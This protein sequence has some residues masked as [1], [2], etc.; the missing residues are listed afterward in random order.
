MHGA[1]S[2]RTRELVR[3]L[4]P[5]GEQRAKTER[6]ASTVLNGALAAGQREH[7]AAVQAA[8]A[9]LSEAQVKA[10]RDREAKLQQLAEVFAGEMQAAHAERDQELDL[11]RQATDRLEA[12]ANKK[13]EES[14]WLADTLA[15]SG[16]SKAASEFEQ[17]SNER[18]ARLADLDGVLSRAG[19]LL[20]V[21]NHAS[22]PAG[23]PAAVVGEAGP[24]GLA[25][26]VA[27]CRDALAGLEG[28]VR[29]AVLRLSSILI[30]GIV[31]VLAG[32]VGLGLARQ[33][34]LW[35]AIG[36]GAGAVL[37]AL[38]ALAL[39]SALRVRVPAAAQALADRVAGARSAIDQMMT[40][41]EASRAKAVTE[42][43]ARRDAEIAKGQKRYNEAMVAVKERREEDEPRV[44]ARHQAAE[45]ALHRRSER[46]R[47]EILD[48]FEAETGAASR[49]HQNATEAANGR[50]D[51]MAGQAQ[52]DYAAALSAARAEWSAAMVRLSRDQRALAEVDRELSP[53]WDAVDW[54]Q[55]TPREATPAGSRFG[56]LVAR[57]AELPGGAPTDDEM[58]R[59][60]P[61]SVELPALLDFHGIGS[62]LVQ[63]GPEGRA[64]AVRIL[65]AT[66]LRLM[67]TF[68]PGKLKF[69]IIDP[70]GL[71]QSFA[72]FMH[73]ADHDES[74]VHDK[75]WTDARHIEQKL[76]D[77]TEHMESV[78][79]K[80]LRNEFSTIQE[81]NT[82]A[83]EVAEPFRFVVIADFPSNFTEAAARK[84]ASI[85]TSGPRCGVYTLVATDT[86]QRPPAWAPIAEL[87]ASSV[88]LSA[89]DGAVTWNDPDYSAFTLIPEDPPTDP[90]VTA[91][92][93][94]VGARAKEA[95][96]VQVPFDTVAPPT[97]KVWTRDSSTELRVPLGKAGA[98]KLQELVLGRGTSQHV[99]IAG[100][101][102]SGKS[103]LLHAMITSAMLWYGPE[104][105]EL[106][107]VDFKKGVEFKTYAS[108]RAPHARVIAVESER[109]FGLSVMRRLDAE[110]SRRGQ[111]YRELGA[112]DLAGFR[113]LSG[114]RMG[115]MPRTLLVVDEFQEFFTEDDKLAQ[116][117]ML[118]MDRL[119]RQGRAF[120]MHVILGSQTIGGAYSLARST[121][122]QMA[123][124]IALQCSEAD[125]YL[126]L[127]EDNSAAR[128]LSRPGEAIY[129][130]QS[131][132]I[133]G[134]SP[135]QIVWVPDEARD[136]RLAEIEALS[137]ST[138]RAG[139]PPIIFEGNVPAKL[140]RNHILRSLYTGGPAPQL[141]T[142]WLG[143][144]ISIKEPTCVRLRRQTGANLLVVG[145]QEQA[146]TG[147][148]AGILASLTPQLSGG[149]VPDALPR[150]TL[151]DGGTGDT[152]TNDA[153]RAC[154]PAA[155]TLCASSGRASDDAVAALYA[156][157]QRR[158]ADSVPGPAL[159]LVVAAMQRFRSLRRGDD[160]FGYGGDAQ[161][162]ET[163]TDKRFAAL[164]RDGPTVGIFCI[165]SV[166][167]S[168]NLDRAVDRRLL[169]EFDFRVLF[170]MSANDSTN[171]IDTTAAG[172][173]GQNRGL[174]YSE[175][176]GQIEKFRPY[177]APDPATLA[178]LAAVGTVG[179]NT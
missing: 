145:Q 67:T 28:R 157:L 75:I 133:E 48:E 140:E 153:L 70:V 116:E 120:G 52:S 177:A 125:S 151:L 101:T 20:R 166:D 144:P 40:E 121:I 136:R 100:R 60:T 72:G 142:L 80:Y 66:M 34:A 170:Q 3:Y 97:E 58:K 90:V 9:V 99:L 74:L 159:F 175:E 83:G 18:K 24:S 22:M 1:L 95:G 25:G 65:Q 94:A 10:K 106:Y 86:R 92:A 165:V 113:K 54:N 132:M 68:P 69:T 176:T 31:C 109:E 79:Q 88:V 173:L 81:Y 162:G 169:K 102:G 111:M 42:A 85:V 59:Q 11:F 87:E 44:V 122:G 35:A 37:A 91:I 4:V 2:G 141:P 164:L 137:V 57:L 174:L 13:L 47:Q 167:T 123:V 135:F 51:S 8:D 128:L 148:L 114:G 179:V 105:L 33:S 96:R 152:E 41:A 134:N 147:V 131:G 171:I 154:A 117:A 160:D 163:K 50:R 23:N 98:T 112:Q 21:G 38:I 178:G 26:R 168:T 39:R 89:K 118:L 73:L 161:A 45:A 138:G 119:V 84:L 6:S 155:L 139:P 43:H 29:P 76:T 110:L 129:N 7:S 77:I 56:K 126:I 149:P 82:R 62:M 64:A 19:E 143:D 32:G 107:L 63:T 115:E 46:R 55:W 150:I 12:K 30:L 127:S 27:A 17:A 130:D 15:E 146:T 78:I 93:H 36:S 156:E 61:E 53:A 104:E 71:G 124:R 103:T 5:A 158:Q 49:T 172:N 16:E 108:H 14:Q